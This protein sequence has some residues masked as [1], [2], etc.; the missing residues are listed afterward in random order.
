LRGR[1]KKEFGREKRGGIR[2]GRECLRID[3]GIGI[4]LEEGMDASES[5]ME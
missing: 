4:D 1:R 5:A 3:D 2:R